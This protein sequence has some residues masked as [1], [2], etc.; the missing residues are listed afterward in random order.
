MSLV[1]STFLG[2]AGSDSACALA[3][4]AQGSVVIAGATGSNDFPTT[5][6]AFDTSY[7]GGTFGDALVT[8]LDMLP[9]GVAAFGRSS[10]G[11]TGA[12]AISVTSM[13]RVGNA[14]FGLTCGNAPATTTGLLALTG[15]RFANPIVVLGV[16]LWIDPSVQLVQIQASSNAVGASEVTLP[17]PNT[18]RLAGA[19]LFA[20]FLW[21]GPNAPPPCPALGFS[22]SNALAITVQ[23]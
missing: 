8:R 5:P 7:N 9:T 16:D 23:P 13:P 1:Y 18:P 19:R 11:C 12:L 17:L 21:L 15:N 14:S 2:G 22:A 10:P 6:G 3:L 4:D 20:Q